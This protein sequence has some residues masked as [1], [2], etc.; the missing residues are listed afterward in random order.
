[1]KHR[2]SRE[3]LISTALLGISTTSAR[4]SRSGSAFV[5]VMDLPRDLPLD[6]GGSVAQPSKSLPRI[7][8]HIDLDAFYVGA[9]R[10]RDPSLRGVPVGIKQKV[11]DDPIAPFPRVCDASHRLILAAT[12]HESIYWLQ[13]LTKPG[14]LAPRSSA[15]SWTVL[16]RVPLWF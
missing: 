16:E 4:R 14:R 11:N 15:K 12:R 2:L 7:I 13:C 3:Q 6:G 10:L 5:Q 8:I 1:M 9:S